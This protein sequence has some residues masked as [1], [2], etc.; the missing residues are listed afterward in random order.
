MELVWVTEITTFYIADHQIDLSRSVVSKDGED[1]QVEPKV[2][3]VLLL[4]AQRQN[5]VVTH[6]EIMEHVWQGTEVVPNALQRCIAILRK[7]LND[8]AKS[9]TIIATHPRIGYRLLAEV[10]WEKQQEPAVFK[11]EPQSVVMEENPKRLGVAASVLA[12]AFVLL[13]A[14]AIY[15]TV[16]P[17]SVPNQYTRVNKLTQTDAHESHATFN[18]NAEYLVFNRYAGSCK[19]HLWAKHL[20]SG[21]ESQLTNTAGN[22]GEASFTQDGREL[23]FAAN[24]E[25]NETE[26][27][28]YT[29]LGKQECWSVATLDFAHALSKPQEPNLRYQCQADM[30]QTP[31]ALPNHQYA[32]LQIQNEQN[33]LVTYDDLSK[34]VTP[35]YSAIEE[36]IYHFDYEPKSKQYVIFS[37]NKAFDNTLKIIDETGTLLREENIELSPDMSQYQKIKGNFGPNNECL[38]AVAD[39]KLYRVDY[40]GKLHTIITPEVNLISAMRHPHSKELVAVEGGKDVDIA[41]IKIGEATDVPVA[42]DLNRLHLPFKSFSRTKKKE[43]DAQFQ[44]GGES[45]AF[46]SNRTGRDQIWLWRDG[47]AQQLE[48]ATKHYAIRDFK[49]SQ[50]GTQL[51][52]ITADKLTIID[53]NGKTK[54]LAANKPLY[55]IMAWY[56]DDKFLVSLYDSGSIK[57]YRLDASNNELT[58]LGIKDVENAWVVDDQLFYRNS[59]QKTYQRLLTKTGK[60]KA[61][62]IPESR[63]M[64][65]KNGYIYSVDDQTLML[66]KYNLQ[67]QFLEQVMQLKHNAWVV[68]DIRNDHMLLS[69]F[70][71]INHDIVLL[72]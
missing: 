8:D 60:G 38:L 9:P 26:K 36:E 47:R 52:I 61:L 15:S 13:I 1:I 32:F 12:F 58:P 64:V 10:S 69:Q 51:A 31:K 27:K 43:R 37:R 56:A 23:V 66:N 54:T 72:K 57:L 35:V 5:E 21:Q 46:I 18:P 53:L 17:N 42:E 4:L 68:T 71:A 16:W 29:P 63:S 25:C 20:K 11:T 6:K 30:V 45:I 39:S 50:D 40:D 24:S 14:K 44:P 62:P 33:Q 67:G 55:S 65:L 70:V 22:Y 19:T 2:L 59:E 48:F 34:E 49:W 3:K 7:V 28:D 41:L